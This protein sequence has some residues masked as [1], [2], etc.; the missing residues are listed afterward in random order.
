MV[1]GLGINRG[2]MLRVPIILADGPSHELTAARHRAV[3]RFREMGTKTAFLDALQ[4][5]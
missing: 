2:A 5:R 1:E 3:G 4:V